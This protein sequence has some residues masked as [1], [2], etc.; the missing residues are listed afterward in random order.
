MIT[1]KSGQVDFCTRSQKSVLAD[2]AAPGCSAMKKQKGDRSAEEKYSV[3]VAEEEVAADGG[4]TAVGDTGENRYIGLLLVETYCEL[5]Y[6]VNYAKTSLVV[7]GAS[8]DSWLLHSTSSH[9]LKLLTCL[10]LR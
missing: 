1:W 6:L 9:T 3:V 2:A 10:T 5:S 8:T 4:G 7:L